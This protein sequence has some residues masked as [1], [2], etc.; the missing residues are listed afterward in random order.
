MMRRRVPRWRVLTLLAAGV[1]VLTLAGTVV[2][3]HA[4]KGGASVTATPLPDAVRVE[5]VT[6]DRPPAGYSNTH[7][8]ADVAT[9]RRLQA[10]LNGPPASG[11]DYG[12]P[13]CSV[14]GARFGAEEFAAGI[15][16]TFTVHGQTVEHAVLGSHCRRTTLRLGFPPD[17]KLG[18]ERGTP[19]AFDDIISTTALLERSAPISPPNILPDQHGTTAP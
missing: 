16:F 15:D 4:P 18:A 6:P 5:F 8:I 14:V 11:P 3:P 17:F 7:F 1:V 13:D 2:V 12:P 19:A 10:E 9:V